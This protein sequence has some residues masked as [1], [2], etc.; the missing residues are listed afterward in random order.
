MN[1]SKLHLSIP[2]FEE[3]NYR[4]KL[5]SNSET[6]SYN[7]GFDEFEG[8]DKETGC[9]DF[10]ENAWS[11]WFS[12]WVNNAPDYFYAYVIKSDEDIPIG[13]VAL[14]YVD[15]KNGYCV[16]IIIEAKY[17]GNGYSEEALRLLVDIAFNELNAEK[18]FDDFPKTRVSAEKV[19]IKIGFKRISEDIVELTKGNYFTL[20]NQITQV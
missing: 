9:I 5:L 8:Y 17:R 2:T 11:S 1:C 20:L 18:I 4:K 19:F 16:N 6:M 3:L 12:R 14:R 7:K 10:K 15:E 13:E